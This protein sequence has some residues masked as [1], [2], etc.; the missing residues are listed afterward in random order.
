MSSR[1][2]RSAQHVGPLNS[3]GQTGP[4]RRPGLTD[5]KST[6]PS[7]SRTATAACRS[8]HERLPAV[9]GRI[10]FAG[11]SARV[12]DQPVGVDAVP[13]IVDYYASTAS[14]NERLRRRGLQN[15]Y[16]YPVPPS[17]TGLRTS[18]SSTAPS[19]R[20]FAGT[21][22]R[23]TFAGSGSSTQPAGPD[24]AL[25][26]R[27]QSL[28]G[29]FPDYGRRVAGYA[30]ATYTENETSR[31]PR[32]DELERDGN[33]RKQIERHRRA[34]ADDRAAP[35]ARVHAPLRPQLVGRNLHAY[36]EIGGSEPIRRREAALAALY[37]ASLAGE[38]L[39][40]RIPD[41]VVAVRENRS[42]LP[43]RSRT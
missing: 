35:A 8:G 15:G 17:V 31:L 25:R 6:T 26:G 16:T 32:G 36:A 11:R 37:R 38:D 30:D 28:N 5:Q 33:V 27:I 13:D 18:R 29:L 41:P 19:E 40:W 23:W 1:I 22:R 2:D 42:P 7:S 24:R 10:R 9:A 21:R 14:S 20:N 4:A 3:I 39:L 34:G 43:R 12:D